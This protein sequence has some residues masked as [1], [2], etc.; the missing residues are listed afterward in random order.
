MLDDVSTEAALALLSVSEGAD[1]AS[2]PRGWSRRRFLQAI[3]AGL[4]GGAAIGP[5]A[6][7][8]M[9]E[10]HAWAAPI[11]P[12]DG[13]LVLVTL[14]G[15]FDGLNTVVPYTNGTYMGLRGGL[16]VPAN[17]V[18]AIDSSIGLAPQLPYV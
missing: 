9:G 17:P 15:G 3:G 14:Y 6:D 7:E 16:A 1:E 18:L 8:L 2:G 13:V 12:D 4:L 11:G 10:A 5:V